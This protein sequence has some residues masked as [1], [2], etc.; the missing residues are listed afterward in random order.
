MLK[1]SF[2]IFCL[3]YTLLLLSLLIINFKDEPTRKAIMLMGLGLFIV[4]VLVGGAL[5]RRYIKRNFERLTVPPESP[6]RKFA[7]LAIGLACIEEF[8]AVLMTNLAPSFGVKIGE[9]FITASANYIDV[10]LFHSVIVF[11]PMLV[12]LGLILR[13]Y[14]ISPFQAFILWG[15][16]GVVAEITFAGPQVLIN[17]P[18]WICIYGLMV[19]LPAHVFVKTKRQKIS[20]F[21]FPFFFPI[22]MFLILLSAITTAWFP[23]VNNHPRIDFV[24]ETGTSTLE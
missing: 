13:K 2:I 20:P 15:A 5:Q 19:Y 22:F 6:V 8:I 4:W 1:R 16:V 18:M 9:A 11:I 17:A 24:T 7:L 23:A 14:D 21:I 3:V 12:M 10:I